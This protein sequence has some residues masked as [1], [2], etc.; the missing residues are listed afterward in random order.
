MAAGLLLR[1]SNHDPEGRQEPP[2]APARR[3]S[4]ADWEVP[5]LRLPLSPTNYGRVSSSEIGSGGAADAGS[6]V[7]GEAHSDT[8]GDEG[9]ALSGWDDSDGQAGGGGGTQSCVPN[10]AE[11]GDGKSRLSTAASPSSA[12][13]R[14]ASDAGPDTGASPALLCA[15]E[16]VAAEARRSQS[17]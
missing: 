10:G 3:P 4:D 8:G 1:Q 11:S 6:Q 15:L 7:A 17:K 13:G 2:A 5:A 16:K 14:R 12:F 9:Y